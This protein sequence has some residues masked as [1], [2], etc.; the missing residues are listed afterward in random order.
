MS[1][2]RKITLRSV[3]RQAFEVDEVVALEMR[4]IRPMM[5]DGSADNG[6]IFGLSGK[7]L[8]K[9]V[10]YCKKHFE[11]PKSDNCATGAVDDDLKAWDAEFVNVY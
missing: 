3:D 8:S 5:K 10:K 4:A 1:T 11:S 9:V 2:N 6:I 7:T